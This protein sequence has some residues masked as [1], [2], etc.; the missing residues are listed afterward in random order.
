MFFGKASLF[1]MA[2]LGIAKI[3]STM[4]VIHRLTVAYIWSSQ[5]CP[6]HQVAIEG[7]GPESNGATMVI[8][9]TQEYSQENGHSLG[10]HSI[11]QQQLQAEDNS[12]VAT[13]VPRL[14]LASPTE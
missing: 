3:S 1:N 6:D 14:L 9:D 8:A 5:S 4:A 10:R 11:W 2:W 13:L 12:S 7:T